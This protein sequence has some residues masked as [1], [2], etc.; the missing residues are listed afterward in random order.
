MLSLLIPFE[1]S[2][3][4]SFADHDF[5][6][7][8][9]SGKGFGEGMRGLASVPLMLRADNTSRV[10]LVRA[11]MAA[12]PTPEGPG[13]S[14]TYRVPT[15]YDN[16]ARGIVARLLG[17]VE[18]LSNL[19][20]YSPLLEVLN[21]ISYKLTVTS[22]H[23]EVMSLAT[24]PNPIQTS[25]AGVLPEGNELYSHSVVAKKLFG[26]LGNSV[27]SLVAGDFS[28]DWSPGSPAELIGRLLECAEEQKNFVA[29]YKKQQGEDYFSPFKDQ[30]A[31]I[32]ARATAA[33]SPVAPEF[34]ADV[35][36]WL[37]ASAL[38]VA[39][40]YC[41]PDEDK[42]SLIASG[43]ISARGNFPGLAMSGK[44]GG[45]TIRDLYKGA[46][47]KI[48]Y[49]TRIPYSAEM[50][51]EDTLN[52]GKKK[53]ISL[54][55]IKKNGF[56]EIALD[57]PLEKAQAVRDAIEAAAVGPFHFGKKGIAYLDRMYLN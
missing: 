1:G 35:D 18:R 12:N 57:L 47:C 21:S 56:I 48:A 19:R 43:A 2:W 50:W 49:S 40:I 24:P 4:N 6:P 37:W 13:S 33:M 25:G 34:A 20:E 23:D 27:E 44:V 30:A 28:G 26:H 31:L 55:V 5:N 42:Q 3:T 15:S 16:T 10:E 52:P 29:A 14:M 38:I 8:F 53:K 54:G 17:S 32:Q 39:G 11:M 22:E 45:L 7:L 9:T 41:L 46:G 36:S 51:L